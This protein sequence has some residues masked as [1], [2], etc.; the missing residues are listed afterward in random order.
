MTKDR[1]DEMELEVVVGVDNLDGGLRVLIDGNVNHPM[2]A[3]RVLMTGIFH[4][5]NQDY[6]GR[7]SFAELAAQEAA[8]LSGMVLPSKQD[9]N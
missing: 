1:E 9:M 5:Y 7:L 6:K 8:L 3:I 4:I 2:V